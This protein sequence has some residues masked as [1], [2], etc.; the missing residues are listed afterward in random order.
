MHEAN[1][2]TACTVN[3]LEE[4]KEKISATFICAH[5]EIQIANSNLVLS[6]AKNI[7]QLTRENHVARKTEPHIRAL[8]LPTVFHRLHHQ[9][10]APP[11]LVDIDW[12][13][14]LAVTATDRC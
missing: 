10:V 2:V 14:G 11:F 4:F 12:D 8:G 1:L 7:N 9:R 3:Q 13:R 5:A 6:C